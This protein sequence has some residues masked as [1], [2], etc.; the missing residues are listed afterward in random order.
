MSIETSRD[1]K[2]LELGGVL[3]AREPLPAPRMLGLD[4]LDCKRFRDDEIDLVSRE[5]FPVGK[6]FRERDEAHLG[7]IV[8]GDQG[9]QI[10]RGPQPFEV[11]RNDG[12][13]FEP[14]TRQQH[15]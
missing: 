5:R 3:D 1:G 7:E 14:L 11:V 15:Q 9:S 12:V 10:P 2:P 13:G 6:S 4:R 8:R